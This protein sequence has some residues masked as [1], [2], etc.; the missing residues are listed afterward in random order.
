MNHLKS[1]VPTGEW[2]SEETPILDGLQIRRVPESE[3]VQTR[4]NTG[5]NYVPKTS[6]LHTSCTAVRRA[7]ASPSG[8]PFCEPAFFF[9]QYAELARSLSQ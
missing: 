4:V 7:A 3:H 1:T 9:I 8:P 6:G 5:P 2:I